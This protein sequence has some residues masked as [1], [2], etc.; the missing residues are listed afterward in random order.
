MQKIQKTIADTL[1]KD[2]KDA[3]TKVAKK[4]EAAAKEIGE[5]KQGDKRSAEPSIKSEGGAL[6][7]DL[8]VTSIDGFTEGFDDEFGSPCPQPPSFDETDPKKKVQFQ[9]NN[10]DEEEEHADDRKMPVDLWN[11]ENS[12]A[13]YVEAT[14]KAWNQCPSIVKKQLDEQHKKIKDISE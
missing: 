3:G 5:A 12:T 1:I 9:V 10:V 7:K 8:T 11:T 14:L 6:N 13:Q 2:M 4:K